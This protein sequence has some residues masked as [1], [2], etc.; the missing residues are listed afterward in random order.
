MCNNTLYL[1][2]Y[3]NVFFQCDI[4]HDIQSIMIVLRTIYVEHMMIL[5]YRP[6]IV[7]HIC[8]IY[9]YMLCKIEYRDNFKT[10]PL[11]SFPYCG[12]FFVLLTPPTTILLHQY[13]ITQPKINTSP[14]VLLIRWLELL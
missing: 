6:Y 2:F 9:V 5:S 8:T 14:H 11:H 12:I 3:S 10:L 1:K 13:N 7:Y 4:G